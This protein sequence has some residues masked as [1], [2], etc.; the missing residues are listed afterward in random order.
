M[1]KS[2]NKILELGKNLSQEKKTSVLFVS[3]HKLE[4]FIEILEKFIP[5]RSISICKELT[6]INEFVFRGSPSKVKND[7]LKNKENLK[8]EFVAVLDGQAQ[9]N[10]DFEDIDS[11][12]KELKKLT[13]KFS[14]TDVVEIVHKFTK[15]NKN[16]IY[17][18]LLDL[19]KK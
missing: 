10:Q 11:Y 1:P 3:S 13:T 12:G 18:W 6:K 14:L 9:K 8:G 4:I 19:K 16:K 2:K 5:K 17:K 15:I 7:I